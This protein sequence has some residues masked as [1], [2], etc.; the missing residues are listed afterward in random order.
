MTFGSF[1]Q[2]YSFSYSYYLWLWLWFVA[3]WGMELESVH[4]QHDV[5]CGC[6]TIYAIAFWQCPHHWLMSMDVGKM[7]EEVPGQLV[8]YTWRYCAFKMQWRV[9]T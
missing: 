6:V 8:G 3:N 2:P 7:G 4:R 5:I 9:S 1:K